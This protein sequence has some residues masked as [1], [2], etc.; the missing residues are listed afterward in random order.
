MDWRHRH[1][2]NL[3]LIRQARRLQRENAQDRQRRRV[4][5]FLLL[6]QISECQRQWWV[7]PLNYM[8]EEEGEFYILYP[9]LRHWKTEFFLMYR[10]YPSKFD[11]LL[12]LVAPHLRKKDT[13]MRSALSPE[14]KLVLTLT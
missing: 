9:A 7:H 4:L 2:R 6:L 8:R 3:V 14:L 12:R 10:M 11:L 5:A 1:L 13:N